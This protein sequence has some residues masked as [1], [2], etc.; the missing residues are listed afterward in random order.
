[1]EVEEKKKPK[2]DQNP[3]ARI[4]EPELHSKCK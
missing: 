1:M 4:G 3:I 2:K